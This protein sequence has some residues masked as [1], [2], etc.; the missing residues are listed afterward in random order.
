YPLVA[1]AARSDAVTTRK[2]LPVRTGRVAVF[3]SGKFRYEAGMTKGVIVVEQTG[4]P[5]RCHYRRKRVRPTLIGLRLNRIGRVAWLPNTPDTRGM[6]ARVNHIVRVLIDIKPL[7]RRRF[8]ALGG[9]ARSP[10]FVLIAEET[11][12]YGSQD[13]RL[14]GMLL[15]D[16][17]DDD[18]G[19]IIL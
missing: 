5:V 19:W 15:R 9:Y 14:I 8:D 1:D 18:Y 7:A 2:A 16:R 4:S 12:W 3:I 17:V 6:I 10:E 13:E 11:E